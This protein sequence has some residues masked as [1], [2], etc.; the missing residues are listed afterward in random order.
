MYRPVGETKWTQEIE[1]LFQAEPE[2]KEFCFVPTL[3]P[4]LPKKWPVVVGT[5]PSSCPILKHQEIKNKERNLLRI[6]KFTLTMA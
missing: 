3:H 1:R 4:L 6:A 5:I 2:V